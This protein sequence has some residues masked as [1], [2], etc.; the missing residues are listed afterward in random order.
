MVS[1]PKAAGGRR[2]SALAREEMRDGYLMMAPWLIGFL[3]LLA[4]PMIA[5]LA[6]SFTNWQM[7]VAPRWLGFA[8]YAEMADDA[9]VRTALGNTAFYALI[10]T[11][12][13]A[14]LGLALEGKI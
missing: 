9:L 14:A 7:L 12:L 2:R 6:I 8:N 1:I 4:G 10:A 11:P 13:Y 5:S 3:V